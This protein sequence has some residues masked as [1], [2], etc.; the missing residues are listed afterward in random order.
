M[1]LQQKIEEIL[2]FQFIRK[3][4]RLKTKANNSIQKARNNLSQ[5]K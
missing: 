2:S 1:K 3:Q 5:R 4:G